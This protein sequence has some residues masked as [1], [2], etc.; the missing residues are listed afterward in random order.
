MEGTEAVIR[1]I[2]GPV[3]PNIQPLAVASGLMEGYIFVDHIPH[4]AI[5]VTKDIYPDSAKFLNKS[6][7]AV[8]RSVERLSVRCWDALRS[9]SE[10]AK[11][12]IGRRV[13]C[14]GDSI[15]MLMFLAVYAHLEIPY[16]VAVQKWPEYFLCSG[17]EEIIVRSREQAEL[18]YRRSMAVRE[19]VIFRDTIYG[20]TAYFACPRCQSILERE[21]MAFCNCCGQKLNWRSKVIK[22]RHAGGVDFRA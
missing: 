13:Q 3:R 2:L 9:D 19:A 15:E 14:V 4:D 8:A 6:E 7:D 21:Y 5:Q 18:S 16:Y 17:T 1:A 12:Y 10:L 11:T 22:I 20:E